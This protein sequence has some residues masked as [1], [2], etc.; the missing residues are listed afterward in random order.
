V[1]DAVALISLFPINTVILASLAPWTEERVRARHVAAGAA[2]S[3]GA[4]LTILS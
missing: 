1:A 3:L 4:T 2:A